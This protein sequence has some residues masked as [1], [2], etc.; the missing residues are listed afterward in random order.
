MAGRS[1]PRPCCTA[2]ILIPSS[3]TPRLG[4]GLLSPPGFRGPLLAPPDT[5][6]LLDTVSTAAEAMLQAKGW[7]QEGRR[8]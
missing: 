3:A 2:G 6:H 5:S 4:W 1:C 8:S 7:F